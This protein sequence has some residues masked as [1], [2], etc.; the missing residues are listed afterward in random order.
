M[1]SSNDILREK[2]KELTIK[3]SESK[4]VKKQIDYIKKTFEQDSNYEW[5]NE[6]ENRIKS[7]Q[8]TLAKLE[9]ENVQ[10]VRML[11]KHEKMLE[12]SDEAQAK[13]NDLAS[14]KA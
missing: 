3:I 5:M 4:E 6:T 13:S 1:L 11:E 9:K 10:L 8:K 2:K 7:D 12:K 14:M